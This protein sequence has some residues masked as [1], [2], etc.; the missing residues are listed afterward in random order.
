MLGLHLVSIVT[1]DSALCLI[2][3]AMFETARVFARE[4]VVST[5]F[6][7]IH[8]NEAGHVRLPESRSG[9]RMIFSMEQRDGRRTRAPAASRPCRWAQNSRAMVAFVKPAVAEKLE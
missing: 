9:R 5:I 2:L 7:R 8:R 1:F 6:H 3:A 4:P